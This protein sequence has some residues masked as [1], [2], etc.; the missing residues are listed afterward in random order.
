MVDDREEIMAMLTAFETRHNASQWRIGDIHYWPLI[1]GIL[2]QAWYK[3]NL[4]KNTSKVA[5]KT[6]HV[7]KNSFALRIKSVAYWLRFLAT[8]GRKQADIIF[9]GAAAHRV[10]VESTQVNRYFDPLIELFGPKYMFVEYGSSYGSQS[11]PRYSI[12]EAL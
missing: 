1:K 9:S 8:G 12:F 11:L 10:T 4:E 3:D 6:G 2:F 5:S 7:K